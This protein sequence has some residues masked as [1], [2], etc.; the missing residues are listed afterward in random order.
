M[1]GGCI[2][3]DGGVVV[4]DDRTEN[5]ASRRGLESASCGTGERTSSRG[6]YGEEAVLQAGQF[7]S[8]YSAVGDRARS[9]QDSASQVL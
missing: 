4:H 2:V 3:G 7:A 8:T 1:S 5:Q 6:G 9:Q